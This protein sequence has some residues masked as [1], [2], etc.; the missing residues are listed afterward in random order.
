VAHFS[1][2]VNQRHFFPGT[3]FNMKRRRQRQGL[4]YQ[5]CGEVREAIACYEEAPALSGHGFKNHRKD[6]RK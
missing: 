2:P 5:G 3:F 4:A 1:K 6:G